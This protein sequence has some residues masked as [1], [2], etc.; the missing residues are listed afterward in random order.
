MCT[1]V[2]RSGNGVAD[3]VGRTLDMSFPGNPTLWWLPAGRQMASGG[4]R[5]APWT[6]RRASVAITDLGGA[7][8]DGI[9]ESGLAAHALMDTDAEYEAVD[10]RPSVAT[11]RWVAWVLDN[12]DSVS[13]SV[14]H[15]GDVRIESVPVAGLPV[16]VH[17]AIEDRFGDSAIV[18]PTG[19]RL[20]VHHGQ[21][22][23]VMANAPNLAE[24]ETNLARYR[25][26]GGELPPPGDITSLDRFVR[27]SY[28]LHY[29]PTPAD[30]RQAVAEVMQV[31]ST[32]A[33]PL[34]VPYPDG[35]VYPTRWLSG[36]DL[37]NLDYYFWSRTSPNAVWVSVAALRDEARTLA[38]DLYDPALTGDLRAAMRPADSPF[39]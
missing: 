26:F 4:D 18:E 10:D 29:L 38:V 6:A 33:K 5:G 36:A 8:L 21:E 7:V 1:R 27:A 24:H 20:V 30:S 28:F 39:V 13:E 31:L 34:G 22:Y 9:N 23:R 11:T 14:R 32:V 3:V 15:L 12:F 17:F 2:F 37:T 16:G 25:P 19:G 35:E